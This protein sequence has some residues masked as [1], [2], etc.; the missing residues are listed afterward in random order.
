MSIQKTI[1]QRPVLAPAAFHL[2]VHP[3]LQRL[4]AHRGIASP[5]DLERSASHLLPFAQLKGIH[6][7]VKLLLD[8]RQ[9]QL[10]ILIVGDFD[11]D[12]AT[13]TATLLAGLRMLGFANVDYLVPNRFEYGYG[14]TPEMAQAA[15]ARGA[16][17]IITVDNGISAIDGV[18]LAKAAGVKVLVTDHHL[19]G[20]DL[21]AADAI[22]NPNQ[23]GCEFPSKALAGCG[24]AFYVLMALR[25][26]MRE[27]GIFA[28]E[29][30]AEPNIGDLLDLVALGTVADVVPLDK[31]NR[32]IVHQGL[33]RIRAGKVRPGIQALIDVANRKTEKLTAQDFGFALAPR[34]NAAGRLDDMSIGIACLLSPDINNARRLAAELDSLN[35]ERREIEQ[36]MQQ[37]AMAALSRLSLNSA[38]LPRCLCLYQS[39]WHQGVIGI[40]AGRVKEAWHRPVLAFAKGDEGELKGSARSVP[41]VHI[42]DLLEEV[43]TAHPGLIKKF[44]GHAMAAGL[45]VYEHKFEAFQQALY[46]IA[47][48]RI[49][50]EHL[51][52]VVYSDGELAPH[53]LDMGLAQLLQQ[54]GPWGQAFPEPVFHGQF[55]LVQ[56]RLL[57][58]KHLKLMLQDAAGK[59]HDAIWFYCDVKA[60]P[61]PQVTHVTLAYQL[62]INEFRDQ[63]NLQ[64]LVRHLQKA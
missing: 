17:L 40:L 46:D 44:G 28:G 25:A 63:Q 41:G 32:I 5:P 31:N 54:A 51:T 45:T 15:I 36:G 34:L 56:Q 19:P 58:E 26:T 50:D 2:P 12:G 35:I 8:A 52:A 42:R 3:V 62:D 43:S 1:Q 9:A 38:Q 33:Q 60:W 6:D 20:H 21:P 61:D 47:E 48:Q 55:K 23:P 27:R 13:S 14:L 11:A 29:G 53:E 59:L 24:V 49:A 4:Y 16:Q 10:Q 22:V 7:A 30:M 37:E 18:A 64:L 57:A 39:D